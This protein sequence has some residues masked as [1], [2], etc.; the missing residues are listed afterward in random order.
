MIGMI[1]EFMRASSNI[2]T[3]AAHSEYQTRSNILPYILSSIIVAFCLTLFIH[4]NNWQWW[5]AFSLVF[6]WLINVL[7]IYKKSVAIISFYFPWRKTLTLLFYALAPALLFMLYQSLATDWMISLLVCLASGFYMILVL[8]FF[9][10]KAYM[11]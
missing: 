1:I 5:L 7:F 9:E 4:N 10:F 2:L 11:K 3:H 8:Y 6:A